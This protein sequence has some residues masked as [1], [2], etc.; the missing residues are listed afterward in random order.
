MS[1]SERSAKEESGRDHFPS[2]LTLYIVGY[3]D[4][5]AGIPPFIIFFPGLSFAMFGVSVC[6][7]PQGQ[8]ERERVNTPSPEQSNPNAKST[9][10]AIFSIY[11]QETLCPKCCGIWASICTTPPT[12]RLTRAPSRTAWPCKSWRGN[13]LRPSLGVWHPTTISLS[14]SKAPSESKCCSRLKRPKSRPRPSP[15]PR[16]GSTTSPARPG[17]PI[18]RP[19]SSG[20]GPAT[21]GTCGRWTLTIKPS[22][23]AATWP[24]AGWGSGPGPRITCRRSLAGVPTTKCSVRERK[25]SR[26]TSSWRSTVSSCTR[27]SLLL[28]ISFLFFWKCQTKWTKWLSVARSVR[29][30]PSFCRNLFGQESSRGLPDWLSEW[31][32]ACQRLILDPNSYCLNRELRMSD[33]Y[34][35]DDED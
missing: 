10:Q 29:F 3:I 18:R 8:R 20:T 2:T 31:V 26:I 9:K 1:L 6:L 19:A 34:C 25:S 22:S 28:F 24:S 35:R 15:W 4:G 30:C 12:N 16:A 7:L 33:C 13:T 14:P 32:S 27:F 21:T 17:A 5:I 11:L 23:T